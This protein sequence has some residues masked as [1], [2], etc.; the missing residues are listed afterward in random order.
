[1]MVWVGRLKMLSPN[2]YV[3]F[4]TF[5]LLSLWYARVDL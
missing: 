1:M 4:W 2:K 3:V 5:H